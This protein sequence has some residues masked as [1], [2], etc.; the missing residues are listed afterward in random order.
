MSREYITS[1]YGRFGELSF[2]DLLHS[3]DAQKETGALYL[4]H[5][6]VLKRLYF[7]KGR[8]VYAQTSLVQENLLRRLVAMERLSAPLPDELLEASRRQPFSLTEWAVSSGRLRPE[9]ISEVIDPLMRQRI[10]EIFRWTDGEYVFLFDEP[11]PRSFGQWGIEFDTVDLIAEGLRRWSPWSELKAFL[12]GSAYEIPHL[13]A[14]VETVSEALKAGA[15]ETKILR[16]LDG[17]TPMVDVVFGASMP[18]EE[19][20]ILLRRLR[21][22]GYLEFP[23]D[24]PA[25]N[26]TVFDLS[27][28]EKEYAD[29]LMRDAERLLSLTP[30]ELFGIDREFTADDVRRGYYTLAQ[31]YHQTEIVPQLPGAHQLL[32]KR[33]FEQA[34]RHFEALINWVKA[35]EAGQFDYFLHLADETVNNPQKL[36][37][38][39]NDCLTA[40]AA[41]EAGEYTVA[42]ELL[43]RA[44]SMVDYCAEYRRQKGLLAMETGKTGD[45]RG[46]T[47]SATYLNQAIHL[48]AYDAAAHA[49]LGRCWEDAGEREK[50]YQAY[51]TGYRLDRESR[52]ALEGMIRTRPLFSDREADHEHE[53]AD[54]QRLDDVL[55][56]VEEREDKDLYA[57]LGLSRDA[58][59]A[60]VKAAYF[61]L[62]RGLHPDSLGRIKDH[63]VAQRAFMMVNEAYEILS[64]RE[65]RRMYDRG[66]NASERQREQLEQ[67]KRIRAQQSFSRAQ[68]LIASGAYKEAIDVLREVIEAVPAHAQAMAYR[69]WS[70]FL[71]EKDAPGARGR[72]EEKFTRLAEEYPVIEEA[73]YFGA[74]LALHF[75]DPVRA[76]TW[77]VKGIDSCE[78][79]VML[80]REIR[81][82]TQRTSQ[83]KVDEK[84]EKK[85]L[86]GGLLTRKK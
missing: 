43:K 15:D 57:V 52:A 29:L 84:E 20:V 62:A 24:T 65:K 58:T 36:L 39:E 13:S 64:S 32:A 41:R 19:A 8:I 37:S 79:S 80:S 46:E 78:T 2:S 59:E 51:L 72:A 50:A 26:R 27:D 10:L 4:R 85:G 71:A 73:Y 40:M 33:L 75:G 7:Q 31:K 76:R 49:D 66:M 48:D 67:A 82:L 5:D 3:L 21:I 18:V 60:D 11:A 22:L 34:S 25:T 77:L 16:R 17:T 45:A 56:F 86:L 44:E 6:R 47:P 74:K 68:S 61:Q 63:P 28:K 38:A 83:R 14:P 35:R 69:A 42:A 9:E 70:E 1:F 55:R 53:G 23:R 81:L 30:F 54:R 12:I